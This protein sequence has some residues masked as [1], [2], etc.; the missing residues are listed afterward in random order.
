MKRRHVC[1]YRLCETEIPS[2]AQLCGLHFRQAVPL[3][4]RRQLNASYRRFARRRTR[5]RQRKA[6]ELRQ[7]VLDAVAA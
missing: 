2:W 7:K 5:S 3:E 1:A 4:L 6:L